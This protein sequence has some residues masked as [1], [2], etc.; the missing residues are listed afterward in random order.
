MVKRGVWIF[1]MLVFAKHASGALWTITYPRPL[2][3]TDERTQY[4]VALL[5]LALDKTGV[6]YELKPSG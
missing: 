1:I 4:P 3:E 5:K 6:N 2:D